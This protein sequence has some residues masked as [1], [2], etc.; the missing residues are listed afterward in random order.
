[1]GS[2]RIDKVVQGQVTVI[3]L[4]GQIEENISLGELF[5]ELGPEI[6]LVTKDVSRINSIGTRAWI[7][8]FTALRAQG[9]RPVL[10]HCSPAIMTQLSL[11]PDFGCGM[12]V[13]SLYLPYVCRGCGKETQIL[14]TTENLRKSGYQVDPTA[15]CA[16]CGADTCEFD[17][18]PAEFLNYL[19]HESRV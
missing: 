18:L 1:M 6:Y 15:S 7:E 10:T 13:E 4:Q 16:A 5:G 8:Y 19:R 14:A 2:L 9:K 12:L 17:D 3:R 11:L